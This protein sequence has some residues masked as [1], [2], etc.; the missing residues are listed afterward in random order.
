[1]PDEALRNAIMLAKAALAFNM[2]IVITSSQEDHIQ[3]PIAS[4]LQRVVPAA[5]Q[6][7]IKRRDR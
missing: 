4:S 5:Y 1:M 2:P 7:R 3:G 6:T